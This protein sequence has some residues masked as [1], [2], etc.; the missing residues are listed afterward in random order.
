MAKDKSEKKEKRKL[1]EVGDK[2]EAGDV[3]M[4][5]MDAANVADEERVRLSI[6]TLLSR[7]KITYSCTF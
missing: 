6:V 2:D 3:S 4:M 7:R 1:K 5:S